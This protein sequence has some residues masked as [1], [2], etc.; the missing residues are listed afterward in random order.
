MGKYSS[1]TAA[2]FALFG[3]TACASL[4]SFTQAKAVKVASPPL[5]YTTFQNHAVLQRDMPI[6]VWGQASPGAEIAVAFAGETAKAT[7]GDSGAWRTVLAPLK[8]GGPYEMRVTSSTGQTQTVSDILMGD[9]Y[10]CSGQ[11]NMEMPLRLA[12]NYDADVRGAGNPD[13]RLFH[14][15]RLSSPA[16]QTSFGAGATWNLTNPETVKDFSAVC[17]L[18]GRELQPVANVP[19]GL[20]EDAWGGSVIQAWI[21]EE[22]LRRLGG[23]DRVL[24]ILSLY[25]RDPKAAGMQYAELVREWWQSHDPASAG[26]LPWTAP[27]FDD[28]AWERISLD[29]TWRSVK[30]PTLKDFTGT[31]LLRK[32]FEL[33]AAQAKGP[34]VLRLGRID[35]TDHTA[36]N[37]KL[38]GALDGLETERVY[39]IPDGVLHAGRNSLAVGVLAGAGFLSPADEIR[40]ECADGSV[41]KLAADWRY[42]ISATM[43][44]TGRTTHAPWFNQLGVSLLYNGMVLPLG[45][46]KFRAVLWYQGESDDYQPQEYARLLPAMIEDWRAKF[47]AELPFFVV[48]LP[49]F[50]PAV[51][52]A[53]ESN[54]AAIREVQ[55]HTANT[56]PGVDL[57]VTIDLGQRDNI[58]PTAKQEVGRRLALLAE[59]KL[60]GLD[61]VAEGPKPIAAMRKGHAVTV[62]FDHVAKGLE[63]YEWDR[64]IGFQLCGKD[65]T[66]RF[67]HGSAGTDWVKLDAPPRFSAVKVRF[68]W[69]DS[70]VCNLYN[71]EGLPAVP[72][73]LAIGKPSARK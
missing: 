6:T 9:V 29:G 51:S 69:S 13:I 23:Y 60:Y 7:A 54:W 3:L 44:Q 14:V 17:Y 48:Q 46:T 41:L 65:G 49:G 1:A 16:P 31:V 30:H 4:P 18:F 32:E 47:G 66:C 61:V 22:K 35:K 72:F 21:S 63:L 56:M 10:L 33:S 52:E 59:K 73:E 55:R 25:T 68:C 27:A 64:P 62:T 24:D 71:S 42:K 15:E 37:G 11:S 19:I 38:T 5:L 28:S 12:S 34:A 57:A 70:P 50:G 40:L 43:R 58:H 2:V 8:A 36:V 39:E 26:T 45:D 20:V 67:A 53:G